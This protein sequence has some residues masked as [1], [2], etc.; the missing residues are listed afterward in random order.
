MVQKE[1]PSRG[2]SKVCNSWWLVGVT[3]STSASAIHPLLST[4]I[5]FHPLL[6]VIINRHTSIIKENLYIGIDAQ[7]LNSG[8]ALLGEDTFDQ[9]W[10]FC[11]F[12]VSRIQMC[13]ETRN[14]TKFLEV[15]WRRVARGRHFWPSLVIL[16]YLE[17]KC[18]W[19]QGIW[20]N[21]LKL[22]GEDTRMR[23]EDEDK[24]KEDEDNKQC[25]QSQEYGWEEGLARKWWRGRAWNWSR[26]PFW[27]TTKPNPEDPQFVCLKMAYGLYICLCVWVGGGWG[28]M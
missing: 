8:V 26:S 9:I 1:W 27:E 21:P 25:W 24:D 28:A 19:K 12:P 10:W 15:A 17:F 5:H 23:N 13:L 6:S 3:A 16:L 4:F 14:M 2:R 22:R 18:V 20:Q 11:C 7:N